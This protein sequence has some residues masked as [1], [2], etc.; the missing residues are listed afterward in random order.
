MTDE[1][2]SGVA[3]RDRLQSRQVLLILGAV[4]L[5]A[6]VTYAAT[7][8]FTA[9]Q[10][11]RLVTDSGTT[12]VFDSKTQVE[13]GSP[14]TASN[15]V[16][17]DNVAFRSQ[18]GSV[19]ISTLNQ[20]GWTNVTQTSVSSDLFIIDR[21]FDRPVGIKGTTDS[22]SV[23]SIDFSESNSA[24]ELEAT[25]G[26][27]WTLTVKNTG[28]SQGTG[29][30]VADAD[31]GEP[32]DSSAVDGNGNVEF[33][34]LDS[35]SNA[36]L[37]IKK[38]PAELKVFEESNPNTLVSGVTLRVRVFGQ[39]S[40]TVIE[41]EVTNGKMDLTGVPKDEPLT[42]TVKETEDYG[43][44]RTIIRSVEQQSE[45]Y[46]INT[47]SNT[48]TADVVFELDDRTGSFPPSS[49]QLF[50]E[51]PITKDFNGDGTE[52]TKYQKIAG[53]LFGGTGEFGTLLEADERYRLVIRNSD[54]NQR[55]LGSYTATVN[56]RATLQVGEVSISS[57]GEKGYSIDLRT[58]YK[59]NDNDGYKE[60][61]VRVVYVDGDELTESLS[62]TIRNRT[63]GTVVTQES[64]TGSYGSYVAT[65]QVAENETGS[66][67]RLTW[68]ASRQQPDGTDKTISGADYA[69]QVSGIFGDV[70]ID[71]RWLSLIGYI[72]IVAIAGLVVITEPSLGGIVATGWASVLTLLGVIAVPMPALGLA[73]AISVFALIG[74]TK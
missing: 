16:T 14:F 37:N 35:V 39:D 52:E 73:G 31:T 28:L 27:S 32:L 71:N 17:L 24:A 9:T 5:L 51:K 60:E 55:V 48:N 22:I 7:T 72:S 54:G 29:L 66:S 11:A 46:L 42:I 64:V 23:S 53:D 65:Y 12:V 47:T 74:R 56:D 40:D 61:F 18:S 41:R 20:S 58:I 21:R 69:G 70:P 15:E 49:T 3:L 38:G 19:R 57:S 44:R 68:N 62:Y 33:N 67:Y 45:I 59:D 63:A 10:D 2:S 30:V 25:A 4:V 8:T 36:D 6:G 13:S 34:E 50:I 43:Y 26:G 1:G